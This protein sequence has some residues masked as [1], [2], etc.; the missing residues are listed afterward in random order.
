[1][2]KLHRGVDRVRIEHRFDNLHKEGTIEFGATRQ[3]HDG[4]PYVPL[5]DE[6]QRGV[7]AG[8]AAATRDLELRFEERLGVERNRVTVM[9]ASVR[10]QFLHIHNKW[11]QSVMQFALSLAKLILKR[12]VLLDDEIVLGQ[13]REA[14]RRL[15]GVE[16]VKLRVHSCDEEVLRHHRPEILSTSDALR[17]VIIELDDKIEPG[18]CIVESDTGNVDA[19][20]S[21]QLNTIEIILLEQKPEKARS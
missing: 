13:V 8:K 6:Y 2:I 14:V 1:V 21:T 4:Q 18:S 10:D 17:D 3:A 15:V 7:E 16:K 19:R 9:L 5:V 12:E 20:F 11:E